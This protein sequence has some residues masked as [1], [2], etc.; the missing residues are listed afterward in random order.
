MSAKTIDSTS[1]RIAGEDRSLYFSA[2]STM[3]LERELE[4]TVKEIHARL[5]QAMLVGAR[6]AQ[7][8]LDALSTQQGDGE[9]LADVLRDNPEEYTKHIDRVIAASE[10][11]SDSR[12][13]FSLR[14]TVAL[15]WA[16]LLHEDEKLTM[17]DAAALYEQ[18][19]G[20]DPSE[21]ERYVFMR[22]MNAF[23]SATAPREL[24]QTWRGLMAESASS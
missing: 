24:A 6:H 5:A 1:I 7:A 14:E 2:W 19:E 23:L 4:T 13:C 11:L 12:I 16:G 3:A 22:V 20:D 18:A 15:L 21:R 17:R 8:A 9:S 10:D